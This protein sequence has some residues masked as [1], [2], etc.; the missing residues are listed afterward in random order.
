MGKIRSQKKM[1]NKPK[2]E[3]KVIPDKIE[4]EVCLGLQLYSI[5]IE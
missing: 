1:K 4:E 2:K 3:I 5:L